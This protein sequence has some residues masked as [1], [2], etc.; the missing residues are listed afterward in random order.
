MSSFSL[1]H[2]I[3]IIADWQVGIVR[4]RLD[5]ITPMDILNTYYATITGSDGAQH[6]ADIELGLDPETI[7]YQQV[8]NTLSR[9]N[10]TNTEN[11][12]QYIKDNH[13]LFIYTL[14]NG[15]KVAYED[16]YV[17]HSVQPKRKTTQ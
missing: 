5:R 13:I 14:E 8:G 2:V 4:H 6:T 1:L 17:I 3:Y 11:I 10:T 7:S 16:G 15:T 9:L 12:P